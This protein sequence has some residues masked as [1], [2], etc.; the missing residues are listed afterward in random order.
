MA[1]LVEWIRSYQS[2]FQFLGVLSLSMLVVSL[3]AF[4]LVVIN[5]PR[6]YFVRERRDPAHQ[7]RRHPL[8][9][10][11]LTVLK[12][13]L[14]F[15]LVLAGIAMLV[16]PGQGVLTILIGLA[17]TNFPGKFTVERRLVARPAVAKA[18]NRIREMAGR[19]RLE[20]PVDLDH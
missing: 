2:V 20:L 13:I 9:W 12:N 8:V 16:L 14:G 3:V 18:L 19:P 6:D 4:P 17:L 15:T 10:G 5:L 11:V 1:D 7:I